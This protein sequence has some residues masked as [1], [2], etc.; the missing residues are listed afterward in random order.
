MGA[1]KDISQAGDKWQRRAAV[2]QQDYANG[3][4]NPRTPW[5]TAAA[6]ADASYRAGV[7]AAAGAGRYA[8]GV[9]RAGDERWRT[10]STQKGPARYAEGVQLA[11]GQWQSGF[12]PYHAAISSLTLP[13]R[14]PTRSPANL[15]R[16]QAVVQALVAVKERS[17]GSAR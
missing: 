6:N 2:A 12:A 9:R 1:I 8:A 5:A 4:S 10:M 13:A 15:Q 14:G 7:T 3:V 16:V 11:V 17:G